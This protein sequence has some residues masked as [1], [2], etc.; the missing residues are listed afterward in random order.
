MEELFWSVAFLELGASQ[1]PAAGGTGERGG[2]AYSSKHLKK[3]FLDRDSVIFTAP[4]PPD[5]LLSFYRKTK[6]R[7]TLM[8]YTWWRRVCLLVQCHS[9]VAVLPNAL[10]DY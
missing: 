4:P 6:I 8:I 1:P 7:R 9:R 2:S 5:G 3:L 10:A